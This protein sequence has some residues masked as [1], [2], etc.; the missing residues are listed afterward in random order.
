MCTGYGVHIFYSMRAGMI[1]TSARN[2]FV[3]RGMTLKTL[4]WSGETLS[5]DAIRLGFVFIYIIPY[6]YNIYNILIP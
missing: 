2:I 5:R 1:L 6:I 4:D 3:L